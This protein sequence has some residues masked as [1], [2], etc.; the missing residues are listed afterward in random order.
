MSLADEMKRAFSWKKYRKLDDDEVG[1]EEMSEAGIQI[2]KG[3]PRLKG[4]ITQ[5]NMTPAEKE[6]LRR[7]RQSYPKK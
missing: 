1:T 3:D 7:L 4:G 2:A 6:R 5:S